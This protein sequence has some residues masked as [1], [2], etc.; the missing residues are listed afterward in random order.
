MQTAANVTT[1]PQAW[2]VTYFNHLSGTRQVLF[3]C[4]TEIE[5]KKR[6]KKELCP[7]F[8]KTQD[9]QRERVVA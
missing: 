1:T 3:T 4:A 6:I 8:C 2:N 5:A 7:T 9:V